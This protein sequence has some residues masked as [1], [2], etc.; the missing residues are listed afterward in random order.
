MQADDHL[1]C[2]RI[3]GSHYA[4]FAGTQYYPASL[5][6]GFFCWPALVLAHCYFWQCLH[7][8]LLTAY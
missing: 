7:R 8:S 3:S 1:W 5:L 2:Q 6:M 4:C